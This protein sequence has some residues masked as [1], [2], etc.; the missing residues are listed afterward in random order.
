[1]IV[2]KRTRADSAVEHLYQLRNVKGGK[3]HAGADHSLTLQTGRPLNFLQCFLLR[4]V[5]SDACTEGGVCKLS[6][7]GFKSILV[8]IL[9]FLPQLKG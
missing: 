7:T 9:G 6:T 2:V 8:W 1:M 5:G 4:R 3:S